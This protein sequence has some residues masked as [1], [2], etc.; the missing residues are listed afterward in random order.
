M[1]G[2]VMNDMELAFEHFTEVR[3]V[4]YRLEAMRP[5]GPPEA[6]RMIRS[7][8]YFVDSDDMAMRADHIESKGGRIVSQI[9]FR[10]A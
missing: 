4:I 8:S 6:K 5:T 10:G 2:N 7:V 3:E 9:E 1:S